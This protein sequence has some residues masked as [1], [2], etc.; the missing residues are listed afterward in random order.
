MVGENRRW[1]LARR[2]TGIVGREHFDWQQ[3]PVPSIREGDFLVRN[4]SARIAEAVRRGVDARS[5]GAA[6]CGAAD[7]ARPRA[8]GATAGPRARE[9]AD[10]ERERLAGALTLLFGI[11]PIVS[12]RDKR[13]RRAR[14]HPR[15][16][17]LGR[18]RAGRRGP[19]AV[20]QRA[21]TH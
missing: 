9:F 16:A 20:C 4:P 21:H 2:P 17:R 18:P 19:R 11:D 13:R 1:V 5:R 6:A 12:L 15:R 14:P 8:G 7:V 3:E 10:D